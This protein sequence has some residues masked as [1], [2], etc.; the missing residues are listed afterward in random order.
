MSAPR[1]ETPAALNYY[2]AG[3][4]DDLDIA[5]LYTSRGRHFSGPQ[6]DFAGCHRRINVV[7]VVLGREPVSEFQNKSGN[8]RDKRV[9]NRNAQV[10]R[11]IRV[12]SG[13]RRISREKKHQRLTGRYFL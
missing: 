3:H 7:V 5:I 6:D 8:L 9:N 12:E 1:V 4:G 2:C 13:N 11:S 10:E